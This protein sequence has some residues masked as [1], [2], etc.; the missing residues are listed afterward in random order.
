MKCNFLVQTGPKLYK[1]KLYT[2]NRPGVAGAA[3]QSPLS[4]I[5]SLINSVSQ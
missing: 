1:Q 4:F 5:H 2:V 3:V